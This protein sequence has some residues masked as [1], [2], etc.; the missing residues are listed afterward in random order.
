MDKVSQ[1]DKLFIVGPDKIRCSGLA[2]RSV[3][4]ISLGK[5]GMRKHCGPS[6][7]APARII[8]CG[9]FRGVNNIMRA[10]ST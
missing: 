1:R 10:R 6:S 2:P 8:L 4:I 5:G 9:H 3:M 7:S